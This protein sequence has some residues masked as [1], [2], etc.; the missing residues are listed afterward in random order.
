MVFCVC[1]IVV[2]IVVAVIVDGP[3]MLAMRVI[4][5]SVSV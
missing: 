3:V 2:A 4:I 1:V 5:I